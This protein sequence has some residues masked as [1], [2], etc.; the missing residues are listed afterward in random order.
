MSDAGSPPAK[1]RCC[2]PGLVYWIER[3]DRMVALAMALANGGWL[4]TDGNE[5]P[6]TSR[7]FKTPQA[8]AKAANEMGIGA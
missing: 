2:A 8:A 3:G 1:A 4:L 6:L 7:N 5:K